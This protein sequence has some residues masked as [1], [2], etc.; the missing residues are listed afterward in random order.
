MVAQVGTQAPGGGVVLHPQADL[1]GVD[2]VQWC[3]GGTVHA[4]G[5]APAKGGADAP[6]R[7]GAPVVDP[8]DLDAGDAGPLGIEGLENAGVGGC[9]SAADE[10]GV[11][12]EVGVL[13]GEDGRIQ[14]QAVEPAARTQLQAPAFFRLEVGVGNDGDL[15]GGVFVVAVDLR[16][17][18][19]AKPRGILSKHAPL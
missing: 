6:A 3:A 2:G 9:T 17:I 19:R 4:L 16:C 15:L 10:H 5:A 18:G 8:F 13:V 12:D 1:L 14:L 7:D 11:H